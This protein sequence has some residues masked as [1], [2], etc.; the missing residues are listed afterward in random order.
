MSFYTFLVSSTFGEKNKSEIPV[1]G[2]DLPSQHQMQD[3]CGRTLRR[4][5]YQPN[6][7]AFSRLARG[8]EQRP[9][10]EF[11]IKTGSQFMTFALGQRWISDTGSDLGLRYGGRIRCANGTRSPLQRK[12]VF[13]PVT[14]CPSNGDF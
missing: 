5:L 14:I 13:M 2:R 9:S 8:R 1:F 6:Y 11:V 4:F 12:T 7:L 3:S 10:F